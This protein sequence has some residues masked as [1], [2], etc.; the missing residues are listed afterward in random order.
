MAID[1]RLSLA[2]QPTNLQAA[3][4]GGLSLGENL[5][6]SGVRD[7]VLRQQEQVGAQTIQQ[8]KVVQQQQ[9]TA[10]MNK[11]ATGLKSVPIANRAAIISQQM[12][13]METC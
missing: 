1:N 8:N 10:F 12:G 9:K 6:N 2:A 5:R 7:A 13:M 11:L 3:I 4:T